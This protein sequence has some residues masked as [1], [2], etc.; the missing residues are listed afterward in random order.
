VLHIKQSIEQDLGI[1]SF[2]AHLFVHHDSREDELSNDETLEELAH[3]KVRHP[4]PKV[5][6]TLLVQQADAQE[7]VPKVSRKADMIF[8]DGIS[9]AADRQ[10]IDSGAVA[11]I[12]AHPSWIV[13]SEY[14]GHRVKITDINTGELI[15]KFGEYGSGKG[16]FN[17]AWGIAITPDSAFVL[18]VDC[19]NARI[20]VLRLIKTKDGA[21]AL[22]FVRYLGKGHGNKKDELN[23]PVGLSLLQGESGQ[24]TVLVT[25]QYNHRVSQ[26]G[27]DGTFIRIFAGS[28]EQGTGDG[29]FHFP[30]GITTL[31]ASKEVAI[32]DYSNHRVQIFDVEG[33]YK[34]QFGA[35]D[36]GGNADA[37]CAGKFCGPSALA[38]DVHGNLLVADLTHRL[39][40]FNPE[41]KH[42]CTRDDLGLMTDD[43]KGIAWRADGSFA[44]ANGDANTILLWHG[45][46]SESI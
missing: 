34:R 3:N 30:R 40:V 35:E 22:E 29:E 38:S 32:A 25:D 9:G 44:I 11:F 31:A 27:L 2:E 39:Q 13:T 24:Q 18:V 15:C 37:D 21:A 10:F 7:V 46:G 17:G 28:G 14:D 45:R 16:Q 23:Y 19:F 8:G 1:A 41:G 6:M 36:E 43:S 5:A 26:F 33:N 12:P 42:L 4:S 20:Q